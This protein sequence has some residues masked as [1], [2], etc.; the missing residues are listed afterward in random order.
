MGNKYRISLNSS[1]FQA[2]VQAQTNKRRHFTEAEMMFMYEQ[3]GTINPNIRAAIDPQGHKQWL[4]SN[5]QHH[6]LLQKKNIWE[7]G[8]VWLCEYMYRGKKIRK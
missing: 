8:C 1:L 5:K 7:R 3:Q 2:A 6:I 4:S